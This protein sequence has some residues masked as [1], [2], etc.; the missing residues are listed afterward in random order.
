MRNILVI[1]GSRDGGKS[2]TAAYIY[3]ELVTLCVEEHRFKNWPRN[4]KFITTNT[5]NLQY[6]SHNEL[7]DFVA[8]FEINGKI[9]VI[10]SRG[11]VPDDLEQDIKD[12]LTKHKV[13][14][15][16]LICCARLRNVPNSTRRKIQDIFKEN[17]EDFT[18]AK[19]NTNDKKTVKIKT[20]S[21]IIRRVKEI[22]KL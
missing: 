12:L 1:R 11:D 18:T 5:S 8:I 4:E 2:T 20:I 21:E 19:S 17:I 9:V 7:I 16:I 14:F 6:N 13:N 3:N 22:T 10:I 15:D